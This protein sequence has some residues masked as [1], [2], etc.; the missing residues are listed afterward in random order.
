MPFKVATNAITWRFINHLKTCSSKSF[1]RK[2]QEKGIFCL[3]SVTNGESSGNTRYIVKMA[4]KKGDEKV[5]Q[6]PQSDNEEQNF[7]EEPNFDDPEGFVDDI[8]DEGG[9]Y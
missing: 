6:T 3:W 7:E 9:P 5:N 8:T 4:K 2:I 1:W